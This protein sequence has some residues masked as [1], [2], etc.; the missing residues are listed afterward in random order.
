MIDHTYIYLLRILK[1]FMGN[2]F[3]T[4]NEKKYLIMNAVCKHNYNDLMKVLD[5]VDRID[6]MVSGLTIFHFLS[7]FSVMY[8][9]DELHRICDTI[10]NKL[11]ID[12]IQEISK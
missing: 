7:L 2:N 10:Y 5:S 6:G 4:T 3:K 8:T 1:F 12:S 9:I 11:K